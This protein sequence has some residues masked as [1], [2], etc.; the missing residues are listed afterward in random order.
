MLAAQIGRGGRFFLLLLIVLLILQRD[1]G[2]LM[3]RLGVHGRYSR[4][5]KMVREEVQDSLLCLVVGPNIFR[6]QDFFNIVTEIGKPS[7][8]T[9]HIGLLTNEEIFHD[10]MIRGIVGSGEL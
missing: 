7:M 4:G 2:S 5:R 3:L 8:K 10:F 9:I 1:S 6:H